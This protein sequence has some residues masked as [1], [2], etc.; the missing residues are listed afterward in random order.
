MTEL[1]DDEARC[2]GEIGAGTDRYCV[3]R[4]RCQ[5][6]ETLRRE[7]ERGRDDFKDVPVVIGRPWPCPIFVEVAHGGE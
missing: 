2:S 1:R 3:R 6:Y 7:R 4:H 5:R